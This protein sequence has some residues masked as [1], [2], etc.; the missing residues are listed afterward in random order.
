MSAASASWSSAGSAAT[1]Q[2]LLVDHAG[3]QGW[4]AGDPAQTEHRHERLG[5]RPHP[6]DRGRAPAP[7]ANRRVAGRI[8]TRR[9]SRPRSRNHRRVAPTELSTG[10]A[11]PTGPRLSDTGAPGS[12]RRPGRRA[13]AS[14]STSIPSASTLTG[15]GVSPQRSAIASCSTG[16]GSSRATRSMPCR[17]KDAQRHVQPVPEAGADDDSISVDARPA[18]PAQVRGDHL[19]QTHV[20]GAQLVAEIPDRRGAGGDAERPRPVAHRERGHVR[21]AV[22]EVDRRSAGMRTPRSSRRPTPARRTGI[23]RYA[24]WRPRPH[25][26]REIP[27]GL[28]LRITVDDDPPRDTELLGQHPARRQPLAVHQPA[29]ADGVAQLLLDLRAERLR[30]ATIDREQHIRAQTPPTDRH[31]PTVPALPV[32]RCRT[33]A[34]C[35]QRPVAPFDTADAGGGDLRQPAGVPT[36]RRPRCVSTTTRPGM[37][38]ALPPL[39]PRSAAPPLAEA[40]IQHARGRRRCDR[41]TDRWRGGDPAMLRQGIE[42]MAATQETMARR[43]LIIAQRR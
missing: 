35:R 9:R 5:D 7:G 34:T 6:E 30:A 11:R 29:L 40:C 3:Q 22:L 21:D 16:P 17:G 13:A 2:P 28:Q 24:T 43:G 15:T 36:A 18:D 26:W 25:P 38:I 39:R 8:G 32:A 14:A 31:L 33:Q 1:E 12:R 37:P 20:P 41:S 42:E 23:G 27:L 4:R 10:G 19:P